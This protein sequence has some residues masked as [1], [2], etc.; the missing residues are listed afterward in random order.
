[1]KI[2]DIGIRVVALILIIF[3]TRALKNTFLIMFNLERIVNLPAE[4][5]MFYRLQL[6]EVFVFLSIIFIIYNKKT[7]LELSIPKF[8]IKPFIIFF[9]IANVLLVS[10]YILNIAINLFKL[11]SGIIIVLSTL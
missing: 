5:H 10:Q 9:I 7:L 3:I 8:K 6:L 2:K 11:Y 1:M 4:A